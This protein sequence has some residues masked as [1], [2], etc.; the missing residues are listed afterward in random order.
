MGSVCSK[1]TAK[2]TDKEAIIQIGVRKE[3]VV[4][5]FEMRK[6]HSAIRWN[7][8]VGSVKPLL[9]CSSAINCVDE[10]TGNAPIHIAAQNGHL[11]LVQLLKDKGANLSVKNNRGN[12]ALHMSI[13]YNYYSVSKLLIASG[14]DVNVK[15][16][17]GHP[18]N[19]GI[20]G[21]KSL[22]ANAIV[23]ATTAKQMMEALDLLKKTTVYNMSKVSYVRAGLK[24]K[25][26]LGPAWTDRLDL[27][28]RTVLH[29]WR[30][31]G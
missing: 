25:K 4:G 19:T 21:D 30:H 27:E 5:L 24:L 1:K 28:F 31:K 12:T 14:A 17:N 8:P 23:C 10:K 22:A 9:H 13:A 11:E 6:I 20:A 15:N 3:Y 26:A 7:K 2:G 18:S 16:N 29:Q